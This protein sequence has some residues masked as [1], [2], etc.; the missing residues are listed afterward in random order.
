MTARIIDLSAHRRAREQA[1]L[2][3]RMWLPSPERLTAAGLGFWAAYLAVLQA[4]QLQAMRGLMPGGI[5]DLK[6]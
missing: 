4:L 6:L 5:D 3:Q 2:D 1:R